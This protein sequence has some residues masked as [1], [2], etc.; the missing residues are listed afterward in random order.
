MKGKG[1][2]W[3]LR[4]LLLVWGGMWLRVRL[5]LGSMGLEPCRRVLRRSS[6]SRIFMWGWHPRLSL[7]FILLTCCFTHQ[8]AHV[9]SHLALTR[10][11]TIGLVDPFP[12]RQSLMEVSW[13]YFSLRITNGS[14]W[15]CPL[16][17]LTDH[18][19]GYASG[20]KS[21]DQK[22]NPES[23]A[24]V[25]TSLP[26]APELLRTLNLQ[27]YVYL[28]NQDQSAWTWELDRKFAHPPYFII[29]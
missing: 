5:R 10:A 19:R 14:Q 9:S 3:S 23:I 21:P 17:I 11:F 22:L 28:A 24:S 15:S 1:V 29:A 16:G 2:R 18:P 25:R 26:L 12:H 13:F 6:G 8:V 4:V 20:E 7:K 27:S